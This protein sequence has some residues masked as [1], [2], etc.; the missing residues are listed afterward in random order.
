MYDKAHLCVVPFTAETP[1]PNS[2]RANLTSHSWVWA[3]KGLEPLP[4]AFDR[5]AAPKSSRPREQGQTSQPHRRFQSVDQ[6]CVLAVRLFKL[7]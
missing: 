5:H 2:P 6:P 1:N 3:V 7:S 4:W